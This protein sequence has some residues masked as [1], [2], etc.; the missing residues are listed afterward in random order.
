M[1][2]R[3]R[4]GFRNADPRPVLKVL[5]CYSPI[6]DVQFWLSVPDLL[7]RGAKLLQNK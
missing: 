4:C 1:A 7:K 3:K 5:I 2:I 6:S